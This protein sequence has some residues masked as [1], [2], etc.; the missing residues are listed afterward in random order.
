MACLQPALHGPLAEADPRSDNAATRAG[1]A[2]GNHLLVTRPTPGAARGLFIGRGHVH[3]LDRR[4]DLAKGHGRLDRRHDLAKGHGRL[5]RT[6][7][8]GC[9]A[10]RATAQGGVLPGEV[11]LQRVGRVLAQ[12]EAVGDLHG[13]RRAP[14][15][16]LRVRTG[17]IASDHLQ[18]RMSAQPEGEGVRGPVGEQVDDGARFEIDQ[19]RAEIAPLATRPIV[20]AQDP[21]RLLGGE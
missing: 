11:A 6:V 15:D 5:D 20:H 3:C 17:A 14:P 2:Q 8:R 1:G 18:L 13:L 21:H 7:Y 19:D 12:V 4:H 16:A 9:V 10:L